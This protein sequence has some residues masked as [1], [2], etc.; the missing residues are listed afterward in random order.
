VVEELP[1]L[2][3]RGLLQHVQDG[4]GRLLQESPTPIPLLLVHS[5]RRP[6]LIIP[7]D[8][9]AVMPGAEAALIPV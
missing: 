1:S 4:E 5:F 7:D 2:L 3:H 8:V 9:L 6:V